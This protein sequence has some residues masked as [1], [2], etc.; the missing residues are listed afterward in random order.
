LANGGIAINDLS[1]NGRGGGRGPPLVYETKD[2]HPPCDAFET[3]H[4]DIGKLGPD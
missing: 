4:A 1:G 2:A 3:L